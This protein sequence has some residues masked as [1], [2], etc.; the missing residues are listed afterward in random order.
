MGRYER[1]IQRKAEWGLRRAIYWQAMTLVG[2]FV[3]FRIHYVFVGSGSGRLD[4]SDPPAVPEGYSVRMVGLE[5]LRPFA[6]RVPDLPLEFLESAFSN[7]DLCVASFF[8]SSLVGYSFRSTTRATVT[9]QLDIW[10]PDG[11]RYTYKTWVEAKH[12]R[13]NLSQIQGY[14]RHR[15]QVADVRARGIWYVETHNYPS[16]LHSYR[17]PADRSLHMGFIGWFTIFGRQVPFR[18][19]AARWLGVEFMRK[20]DTRPRQFIR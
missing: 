2:R 18:T 14:V 12:R 17:H 3:D 20:D 7:G 15:A 10:I 1:F 19:P 11:F 16:L 6:G 5:E 13:R 9:D 8:G 4:R